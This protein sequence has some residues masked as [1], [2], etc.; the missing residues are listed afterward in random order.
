MS[1]T[2]QITLQSSNDNPAMPSCVEAALFGLVGLLA[3]AEVQRVAHVA[4]NQNAAPTGKTG[5]AR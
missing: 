2:S 3:R 5:G 4:A 1:S